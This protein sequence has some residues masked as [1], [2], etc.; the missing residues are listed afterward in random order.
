MTTA[1]E[2]ARTYLES[3]QMACPRCDAAMAVGKTHCE[4]GSCGYRSSNRLAI[5]AG[6]P[7][8]ETA[9]IILHPEA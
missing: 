1:A 7:G 8:D 2:R 3:R 6:R 4:C 5:V 9:A